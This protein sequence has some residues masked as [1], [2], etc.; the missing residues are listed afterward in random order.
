MN[1]TKAS[2]D[3]LDLGSLAGLRWLLLGHFH[4]QQEFT[5]A[6]GGR[7]AYVGSPWQTRRDEGGQ[8]KGWALFDGAVL[9]RQQ[10]L[11]G[12]QHATL[13]ALDGAALQRAVESARSRD[14]RLKVQVPQ[15]QG[16]QAV[17]DWLAAEAPGVAY[18]LEPVVEAAEVTDL[19]AGLSLETYAE[20]HV[21]H[22]AAG[23]DPQLLKA[24]FAAIRERAECG[25]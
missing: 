20:H 10:R 3:G 18:Q 5:L 12:P 25:H 2:D 6:D 21:E 4:R 17:R 23:L 16:V 8:L 19:A 15:G 11:W 13:R 7:A 9:E 1:D 22:H 14:V 24:A